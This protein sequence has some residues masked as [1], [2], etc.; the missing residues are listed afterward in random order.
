MKRRLRQL[1]A[2]SMS[3][4]LSV[5]MSL[6]AI[7]EE[8]RVDDSDVNEGETVEEKSNVIISNVNG[9]ITNLVNS[10]VGTVGENGFVESATDSDFGVVNGKVD[11]CLAGNNGTGKGCTIQTINGYVGSVAGAHV[12][13]VAGTPGTEVTDKESEIPEEVSNG[14]RRVYYSTIDKNNSKIFKIEDRSRVGENN[15]LLNNVINNN[16]LS[17]SKSSNVIAIELISNESDFVLE[18]ISFV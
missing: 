16:P 13:E 5:M 6:S 12:T 14:I 2:I 1:G 3:V 17:T 11:E 15:G 7:A 18:S 9:T 4:V 10:E 8:P